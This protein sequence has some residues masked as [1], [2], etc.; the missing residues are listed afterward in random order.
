MEQ[1]DPIPGKESPAEEYLQL[2]GTVEGVIYSNDDNGY[3]VADLAP[4]GKH[5]NSDIVTIQGILPFIHEG[6]EVTVYGKWVHSPK[7]GRQFRVEQWERT[8][9]S[10]KSAILRYLSARAI[11]GI[12][13]K[14]AKRIVDEFGE[15]TFDVIENH[16]DWLASIPGISPKRAAEISQDYIEK[17]G[18]HSAM[19]FFREFFG[20]TLSVKIYKE[21]GGEAVAMAK[22]NPFRLCNEIPNVSFEKADAIARKLG[23]P[24]DWEERVKAG[25]LYILSSNALVNGH[26]C[27]PREKLR[28]TAVKLLGVSGEKIE[29]AI[30]ELLREDKACSVLMAGISYIYGR[31]SYEAERF[32]A[33]KLVS[34]DRYC[35]A[36]DISDIHAFIAASERNAAIQYEDLQKQAI[37]DALQSGV[38]ILTGGPGTGK[39]TVVRALLDI[40]ESLSMKV[41]LGAPT[42][43]AAKRLS[44][45]TQR[46]AKTIHRLLEMSYDGGDEDHQAVFRRN[47][48]DLLDENVI[49]VDEASMID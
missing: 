13:P 19:L 23:F 3:A 21:W 31:E 39:T 43:R 38:M 25:V 1:T 42:G 36:L 6:D 27:L 17:I 8:L 44:E 49:I 2:S 34:L 35:A 10:G 18:I 48:T 16:P 11:H 29:E 37:R 15:E 28:D 20:A 33:D 30:D 32:I 24:E 5:K 40:F 47:E 14:T 22:E 4:E 9:P 41:A 26:V 12:G 46:E 7:Y 45:S